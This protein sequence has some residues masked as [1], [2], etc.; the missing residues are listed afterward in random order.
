MEILE[1]SELEKAKSHITVD[2]I[3]YLP[4]SVVSKTM[5]GKTTGNI[6]VSSFDEGE[7][8]AEKASPFDYH[9]HIIDSEAELT[10]K[11]NYFILI[12]GM[13]LLFQPFFQCQETV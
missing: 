3:Q 4:N 13:D 11:T 6:S 10:I 1:A 2:I 9:V 7:V 8:L 12:N 5:I